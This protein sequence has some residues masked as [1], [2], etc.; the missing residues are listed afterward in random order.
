MAKLLN[1]SICASVILAAGASGVLAQSSGS[2]TAEKPFSEFVGDFRLRY[3][4]YANA[5]TLSDSAAFNHREY[6]R[7]R[8]RLAGTINA[9]P[10]LTLF[11]R[12]A[13]EPRYWMSAASPNPGHGEEWKYALLENFYAKWSIAS[14]DLPTT[15]TIGRQDIQLGDQWLVSDGTPIDGSWTNFFDAIR[16]T[17][18]AKEVKTKL[19]LIAF[20]Q[21]AKPGD[22]VPLLGDSQDHGGGDYFLT[23][24]DEMGV[25]AYASNKSIKNTQIDGYFMFKGDTKVSSAGD[26]ADI[27][28]LGTKVSGTPSEH[29]QYSAEGAYQWGRRQLAVRY[30]VAI[31]N[32]RSVEAYG[33][34]AKLTYLFKDPLNNQVALIGE[35]LSGD[36]ASSTDKDEMFD[37][38]WGR[39]P[40]IGET[41]AAAYS[42]EAGGRVSQYNNLGRLGVTWTITPEKNTTITSMYCALFAP[43]SVP[44]RATASA[45]VRFS[46]D[47]NFR[48]HT[49]QLLAK[50]KFNKT[51][52]ALVLA[53]ASFMGDYYAEKDVMTFLR[54]ELLVSF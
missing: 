38:L 45:R 52:S 4:G 41:W 12:L 28:T 14:V 27:Y 13:A 51:L 10:E 22:R 30:P 17:I 40:R 42:V 53:E 24:Q 9:L 37:A 6:F 19:E 26:N 33:L 23:E 11:G 20:S 5:Q 25:I 44:T 36:R 48:G 3:E 16:V 7:A 34:N 39:Y 54:T 31:S 46:G 2:S 1:R 49:L 18:D 21:Q 32:S 35:Y 8:L 15:V 47:G 43:E 29:W 50:H